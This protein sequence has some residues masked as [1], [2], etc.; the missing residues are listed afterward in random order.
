MNPR[1]TRQV[2][3]QVE[4]DKLRLEREA[5]A[6]QRAAARSRRVADK[7]EAAARAAQQR[8]EEARKRAR[9]AE[10]EKKMEE[11]FSQYCGHYKRNTKGRPSRWMQG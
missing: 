8:V 2:C 5:R 7:E 10:S 11:A 6:A 4:P 1:L 3:G 9:R